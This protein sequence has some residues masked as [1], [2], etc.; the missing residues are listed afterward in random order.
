MPIGRSVSNSRGEGCCTLFANMAQLNLK[1]RTS[2]HAILVSRATRLLIV[3]LVLMSALAWVLLAARTGDGGLLDT[4]FNIGAALPI[5]GIVI[6]FLCWVVTVF[7]RRKVIVR[8]DE[9]ITIPATGVRF[10]VAN[11]RQIC[12]YSQGSRSFMRFEPQH[13]E[14]MRRGHDPYTVEFPAGAAP[15]PYEVAQLV[16]QAY[17]EIKVDKVGTL[18][19]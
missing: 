16:K 2:F 18:R 15:R 11:L 4:L 1:V 6:A 13:L 3:F 12:L 8:I 5:L 19:S 17:P 14:G 9:H 10:P 7:K